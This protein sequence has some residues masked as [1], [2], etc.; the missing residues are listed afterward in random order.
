MFL[1]D[2]VVAVVRRLRRRAP[3]GA[4][5]AEKADPSDPRHVGIPFAG[6]VQ[7]MVA[8]GDWVEAGHPVAMIEAMKLEAAITAPRT[9][10]VSRLVVADMRQV[11][12][13]DLLLTLD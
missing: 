5:L 13:G 3:V 7:A 9:G 4:P 10:T 8:E 1:H 12:G 2:L 11:E 6:V